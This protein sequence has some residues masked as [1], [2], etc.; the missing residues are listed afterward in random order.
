M[1]RRQTAEEKLKMGARVLQGKIIGDCRLILGDCREVLP[2]LEK[3]CALVTDPPYGIKQHKGMG[4]SGYDG[5]GK[6]VKRKPKAYS[7]AWDNE[8]PEPEEF[9]MMLESAS[10]HIIWGGN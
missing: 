1:A 9:K 7:G 6:S 10:L 5:F 3:A 8:R 2:T 4:G